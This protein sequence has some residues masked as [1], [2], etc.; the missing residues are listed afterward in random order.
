MVGFVL[1]SRGCW[2]C[3][4]VVVNAALRWEPRQDVFCTQ[5]MNQLYAPQTQRLFEE[6]GFP[7]RCLWVTQK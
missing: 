6:S 4:Q 3:M 1:E 5:V 2:M 7:N